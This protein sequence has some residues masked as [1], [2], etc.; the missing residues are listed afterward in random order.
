MRADT[1]FGADGLPDG[2]WFGRVSAVV[3]D[4]DGLVYVAHRGPAG[5]PIVV[6]TRQVDTSGHGVAAWSAAR[7]DC[8]SP[9]MADCG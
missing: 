2:W 7:T 6:P 5:D 8:E 1:R 3:T 4:A 9:L